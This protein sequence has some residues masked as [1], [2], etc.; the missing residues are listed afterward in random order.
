MFTRGR[1]LFIGMM[2]FLLPVF[3]LSCGEAINDA[4]GF[5]PNKAPVINDCAVKIVSPELPSDGLRGDVL[6]EIT[7]TANDPENDTLDYQFTSLFGTFGNKTYNGGSCTVQFL[8]D[9][10]VK[11]LIPVT[12]IVTVNDPI[13]GSTEREITVGTGKTKPEVIVTLTGSNPISSGGT[14][15]ISLKADCEGYYQVFCDNTLTPET[16]KMID[17]KKV[18]PYIKNASGTFDAVTLTIAGPASSATTDAK[19]TTAGMSNKVWVIF[20]D[21]VNE[22]IVKLCNISVN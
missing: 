9:E 13:N 7:V 1:R 22:D 21:Y 11:P 3:F 19:L 15:T 12:V 14:T 2:A 5:S 6:I 16:A 10:H 8:T 18:I 20:C 17:G 4:Q